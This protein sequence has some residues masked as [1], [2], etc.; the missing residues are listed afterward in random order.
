[1]K[2][3]EEEIAL[4]HADDENNDED[5]IMEFEPGAEVKYRKNNKTGV[6]V[7]QRKKDSWLV[8]FGN[9]KLTIKT[10]DL[11]VLKSSKKKKKI[12]TSG[13]TGYSSSAV[14]ELD[15]RGMRAYEAESALVKQIDSALLSGMN[16]FS[17]IHGLGEGVLQKTVQDFLH[18]CEA[19]KSFSFSDPEHGGFGKTIVRL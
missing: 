18:S 5:G 2:K 3:T 1:M 6:L 12:E 11:T 15:L 14:F 16:E 17:I 13:L 8:A 9:V 10:I 7:E 19:V 4:S